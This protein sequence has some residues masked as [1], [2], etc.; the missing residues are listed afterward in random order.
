MT[1]TRL[2]N[3]PCFVTHQYRCKITRLKMHKNVGL[4]FSFLLHYLG[5]VV[6]NM[7]SHLFTQISPK[8]WMW[9]VVA[10]TLFPRPYSFLSI[11]GQPAVGR[12]LHTSILSFSLVSHPIT[13]GTWPFSVYVPLVLLT[14]LNWGRPF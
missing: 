1:A 5:S 7:L 11:L 12:G 3:F 8:C 9:W 2:C 14:S 13:P 10:G 6:N 4:L